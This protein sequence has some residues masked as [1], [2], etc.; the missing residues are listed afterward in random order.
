MSA[1]R[2]ADGSYDIIKENLLKTGYFTDTTPLHLITAVCG[3]TIAVTLV[4]PVDVIKSR[5][6][7]AT[8]QRVSAI[9]VTNGE[10]SGRD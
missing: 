9:D 8:R 5:V 7:S 10:T 1:D 6:Q 4:A 3:G 2:W